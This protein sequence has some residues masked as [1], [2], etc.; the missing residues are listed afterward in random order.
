MYAAADT[1]DDPDEPPYAAPRLPY[2]E[3]LLLDPPQPAIAA[4]VVAATRSAV[5]ARR[6][7]VFKLT[8]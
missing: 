1:F 6:S 3:L 8:P 5:T 7:D 4:A 2:A